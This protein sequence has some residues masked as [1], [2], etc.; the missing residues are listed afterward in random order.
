MWRNRLMR[1]PS[2]ASRWIVPYG[3]IQEPVP[4]LT[5]TL[6]TP[7]QRH[8]C[9]FCVRLARCDE[10]SL[11]VYRRWRNRSDA[12]PQS[13]HRPWHNN[14]ALSSLL[15]LSSPLLSSLIFLSCVRCRRPRGHASAADDAILTLGQLHFHLLLFAAHSPRDTQNTVYYTSTL[16]W[17]RPI[18][19]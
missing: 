14:S 6:T 16:F 4:V 2:S 5:L 12:K 17:Q 8:V 3:G 10:G 7:V 11:P 13:P 15:F 1:V 19:F 9:V 18:M